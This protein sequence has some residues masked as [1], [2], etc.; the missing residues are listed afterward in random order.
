MA[1]SSGAVIVQNTLTPRMKVIA[2]EYR[3]AILDAFAKNID[4][5][6][7]RTI[8]K[9]VI[10]NP[11]PRERRPRV[12]RGKYPSD[13]NRLTSRTGAF[14]KMM[15]TNIGKWSI[16]K[17]SR[18]SRSAA[19]NA[20]VTVTSKGT[21]EPETYSGKITANVTDVEKFTRDKYATK[22][23]LMARFFH[24]YPRGIRGKRRP[25][26]TPAAID[27]NINFEKI[28]AAKLAAIDAIRRSK[29]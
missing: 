6:R 12:L 14:A 20:I 1:K 13:P 28:V 10:P 16:T 27:E 22:Q 24:D 2:V 26:I 23:K 7:Q 18:I 8:D 5:I 9:Y 3:Q 29:P 19:V 15:K 11:E 21:I 17:R 4:S 25:N